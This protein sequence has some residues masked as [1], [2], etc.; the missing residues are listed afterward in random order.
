MI[1]PD[2]VPIGF[3]N[4]IFVDLA[5]DGFDPPGLPVMASLTGAEDLP[6]FARVQRLDESM[7]ARLQGWWHGAL[8]SLRSRGAAI[9]GDEQ[10]EVLSGKELQA[11]VERKKDIPT[12][13]YFPLYRFRIPQS[14]IDQAVEQLPE[15]ERSRLR[16][17]Q[18]GDQ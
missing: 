12:D 4:P 6:A 13:N 5:G 8:A 14:A 18:G 17:E 7:F 2:L 10:Q 3:T 1:V 11:D 16:T 9:A 15:P